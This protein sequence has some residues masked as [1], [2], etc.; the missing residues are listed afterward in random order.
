MSLEAGQAENGGLGRGRAGRQG[1]GGHRA[2]CCPHPHLS[3]VF[4]RVSRLPWH[5][6]RV[7]RVRL[8]LMESMQT[9]SGEEGEREGRLR[10]AETG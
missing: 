5:L 6:S 7:R 8:T 9:L 4:C 10:Q 2:Y 3:T 1:P